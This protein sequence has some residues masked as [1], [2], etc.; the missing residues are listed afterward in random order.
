VESAFLEAQPVYLAHTATRLM[1]VRIYSNLE[2]VSSL[3]GP[4]LLAMCARF[5]IGYFCASSFGSCRYDPNQDYTSCNHY[6]D[7]HCCRHDGRLSHHD[8]CSC[9]WL[10]PSQGQELLRQSILCVRNHQPSIS[11]AGCSWLHCSGREGYQGRRG[12]YLLLAVSNHDYPSDSTPSLISV[13]A[14]LV[15]R[16]P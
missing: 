15:P 16:Y 2:A 10:K 12:W 1:T 7:I 9:R 4:R 5:R 6:E 8:C 11:L 3:T 14:T 13:P